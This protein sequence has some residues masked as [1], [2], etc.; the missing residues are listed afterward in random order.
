MKPKVV[1]SDI[2]GD[3]ATLYTRINVRQAVGNSRAY[4]FSFPQAFTFRRVKGAWGLADDLYIESKANAAA[5]A[6]QQ[7]QKPGA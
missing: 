2:A 5:A 3:R 4:T 6:A 1:G 7:A